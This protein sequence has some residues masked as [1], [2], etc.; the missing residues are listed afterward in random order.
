MS[1]YESILITGA[2]SGLGLGVAKHYSK[3]ENAHIFL[4]DINPTNLENAKKACEELGA[5]VHTKIANIMDEEVMKNVINE[6]DEIKPLDLIIANA[7]AQRPGSKSRTEDTPEDIMWA[8]KICVNGV[9]NTVFP[10]LDLMKSR[11][12]GH[13]V[14]TS[15]A[16]SYLG[17]WGLPGYAAGKMWVR[18]LAEMLPT[19]YPEL[20]F[21]AIA[22]GPV[23]TPLW[24]E[25][26]LDP[27]TGELKKGGMKLE[28]LSVEE[29]VEYYIR[30][31]ENKEVFYCFPPQ[32]SEQLS[33]AEKLSYEE[34]MNLIKSHAN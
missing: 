20:T 10:A 7:A 3:N 16:S 2:A 13:I 25:S 19:S 22:P 6:C 17:L 26:N 31:I 28:P 18:R 27:K 32:L 24:I 9:A 29:G 1:Q 30:G 15:S 11:G 23:K 21:T 14:M 5:T 33:L 8:T 34:K 12:K 4:I